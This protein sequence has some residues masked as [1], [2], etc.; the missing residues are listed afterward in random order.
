MKYYLKSN[1]KEVS[2]GDTIPVTTRV[3]TVFGEAT[4]T[5]HVTITQANIQKLIEHNIII[6]KDD[7][8]TVDICFDIIAKKMS[9]TAEDAK[10]LI[11]GLI[12]GGLFAPALQMLLKA[13][14]T[15]L[16][17]GVHAV[18]TL[19]KVYTISLIDGRVHEVNTTDIKTYAHFAYFVSKTQAKQVRAM[20][21][22]LFREMYG[23]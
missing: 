3:A 8:I 4:A 21:K 14:S 2:I 1:G 7:T 19:P 10:L 17:P 5:A 22:D 15:Y 11:R 20:L 6:K 16:S 18:K 23:E 9:I 12:E 13:A